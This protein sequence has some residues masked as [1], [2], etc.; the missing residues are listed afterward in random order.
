MTASDHDVEF[1]TLG[2]FIIDDIDF[3]GIRPGVKNITGGAASFAVVGARLVSGSKHAQA[4][5]WIVD[6][7][8]DFPPETLAVI[9]SWNTDCL[10]RED[11]SRLTTRAW[12]GYHPNEQRDFKYLTPKL[13]LEPEM[14]SDRQIWSK[15]FHMVCSASRCIHIVQNILQR[16]EELHKAGNSPSDK[17]ALQR[18][19]FV[20]EPVPDLCTPEEQENFLAANKF[21]D[22]VSPNHMELGMMFD[23]PSWTEASQQGQDLVR[24]I[25]DSGI[26]SDGN[27]MLVIR[28]GKE[29]SYAYS[30]TCK[31]WLPAYHQPDASGATPVVDPTGAGNSFLGALAQGMV[32]TGREP[33]QVIQSVLSQSENWRKGLD[34]WGNFQSHPMALICATVAAGFVVEQI[35]VPQISEGNGEE[36]WN[37]SEFTERVRLYTQ[38]LLKTLEEPWSLPRDTC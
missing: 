17:H 9:K 29:G 5:S 38:R 31:I 27:G 7:G 11:T 6:V 16:R 25:T 22:V 35:G 15:T 12:N 30:K 33:F 23:Q 3:G 4:V 34:S 13:R 28:A 10:F 14:L 36:L 8:S 1:C 19:I 18:P 21:V 37:Q 32:T 24:K 26:G 2:M 20:W